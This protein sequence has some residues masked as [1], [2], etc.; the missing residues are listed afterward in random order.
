MIVRSSDFFADFPSLDSRNT[1]FIYESIESVDVEVKNEDNANTLS[2]SPKLDLF[3]KRNCQQII[4]RLTADTEELKRLK[5]QLIVVE[6]LN[7]EL[8]KEKQKLETDLKENKEL[9][10]KKMITKN[11]LM[12]DL[13]KSYYIIES[14]NSSLQKEL[15]VK[16]CEI[17][18]L[19][20][21]IKETED[22]VWI[23]GILNMFEY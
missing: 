11:R 12:D 8:I 21:H 7:I 19:E 17:I 2:H 5:K 18:R 23:Y 4:K 6:E 1:S 22:K 13:K 16:K 9:L 20:D 15:E 3:C 10:D 14:Y